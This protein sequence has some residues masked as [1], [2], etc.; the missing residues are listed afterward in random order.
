MRRNIILVV[1]IYIV[2]DVYSQDVKF[3][4]TLISFKHTR[5][6][7]GLG[8]E[9]SFPKTMTFTGV[10]DDVVDF[11]H[12]TDTLR[13][14]FNSF[15]LDLDLYSPNSVIGLYFPIAYSTNYFYVTDT[16]GNQDL[17]RSGRIELP[18]FIK[19][20]TG[21]RNGNIHF[22]LGIG[23]SYNINMNVEREYFSSFD[24]Y[25]KD[26]NLGQLNNTFSYGGFI[27]YEIANFKKGQTRSDIDVNMGKT[28][29]IIIVRYT[30]FNKNT[31]NNTYFDTAV[32]SAISQCGN[33]QL[34]YSMF[35]FGIK[36]LY[37]PGVQLPD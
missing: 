2:S 10:P 4:P 33:I 8:W 35:S 24:P 14:P 11:G 12:P 29:L 32:S 20:R 25:V 15:S 5:L 30:N 16:T 17:F 7:F 13:S 23:G 9:F 27:G 26:N 31:L 37:Q 36:L 19:F 1:F 22:W 34:R 21:Q 18:L 6:A 3:K 28:R